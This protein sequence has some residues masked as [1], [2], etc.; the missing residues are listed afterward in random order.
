MDVCIWMLVSVEGRRGHW[1]PG[2]D[3]PGGWELWCGCWELSL[4]SVRTVCTIDD[5]HPQCPDLSF[6]PPGR[7]YFNIYLWSLPLQEVGVC[8]R[9]VLQTAPTECNVLL[10][11]WDS[12]IYKFCAFLTFL[13][14][15]VWK[16]TL[17]VDVRSWRDGF[18]LRM[19]SGVSEENLA[20]TLDWLQPPV[21]PA[22]GHLMP[23]GLRR[24][25]YYGLYSLRH[26]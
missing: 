17:K 23:S 25:S 9:I 24:H 15:L 22:Y 14:N 7:I 3:I 19:L 1:S 8:S 18:P 21:T 6:Q 26:N 13:R 2:V 11:A 4:G 10:G 16:S 5:S 20:F 12:V